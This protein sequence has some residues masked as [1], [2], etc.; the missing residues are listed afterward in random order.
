MIPPQNKLLRHLTTSEW[1]ELEPLFVHEKLDRGHVL[2]QPGEPIRYAHF[3]E[4]GLSSEIALNADDERI[5]VGCVGHEGYSG[6]PIA[7]G[8][9]STPHQS[10]MEVGGSA[11]RITTAD[12]LSAMEAFPR[13]RTLLLQ[14]AHV[15]MIQIAATALADGRYNIHQRLA[16]W[17]LMC[18][19][20]LD[21]DE[22]PLTHEFL[23]LMLGVR[24]SSVTDTLH[25]LEGEGSIKA[26]R[27][28]IVVRNRHRLENV[29]GHSY[30]VP[31]AE[32]K[33]IM[34]ADL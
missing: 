13:F 29:A 33:R 15:F 14:F 7:L 26:T 12:L 8:V 1:S 17:I 6:V 18:H 19:D 5:E 3:F 16:R 34:G 27:G 32:Y 2:H 10:F 28:L 20:R 9:N 11:F 25:L 4:G 22:L 30:G 21:G 24:R 31:E 23:A